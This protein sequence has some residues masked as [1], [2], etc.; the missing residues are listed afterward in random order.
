MTI[1]RMR[2]ACWTPKVANRHTQVAFPLQ[3][4]L[5]EL[6]SNLGYSTLPVWLHF[7]I[8]SES[9]LFTFLSPEIATSINTHIS[10]SL[11]R[12]TMSGL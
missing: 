1:W 4:W 10:F 12:I 11:T 7:I 3:E 9:F 2:I 5:H 6:P 8:F